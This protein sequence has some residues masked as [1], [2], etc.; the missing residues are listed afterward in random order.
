MFR[1][2]DFIN[3]DYSLNNDNMNNLMGRY[4]YLDDEVFNNNDDSNFIAEDLI[5]ME[6]TKMFNIYE[7]YYNTRSINSEKKAILDMITLKFS[8]LLYYLF[9]KKMHLFKDKI[10]PYHFLIIAMKSY[11]DFNLKYKKIL[12]IITFYTD[13]FI[14]Y[15]LKNDMYQMSIE[16]YQKMEDIIQFYISVSR[17][18]FINRNILNNFEDFK[19]E[20]LIKLLKLYKKFN[21]QIHSDHEFFV[22]LV[23]CVE[24]AK[25]NEVWM[26]KNHA[27]LEELMQCLNSFNINL[28][29]IVSHN[30]IRKKIK[31]NLT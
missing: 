19:S 26:V 31:Q 20:N 24:R 16:D 22:N 11:T 14:L 21:F 12:N 4:I 27:R 17:I 25:Q 10:K 6:D 28:Y 5:H 15:Q 18:S 1:V 9:E 3:A 29:I 23:K 7:D 2:F 8:K 13:K 30:D